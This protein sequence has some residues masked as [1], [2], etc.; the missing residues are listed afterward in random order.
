[1][2]KRHRDFSRFLEFYEFLIFNFESPY[3]TIPPSTVRTCPVM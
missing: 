1:M 3:I 2:G